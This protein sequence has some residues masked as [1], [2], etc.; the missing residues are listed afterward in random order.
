MRR[1]WAS[2]LVALFSFSLIVPVLLAGDAESALPACCRRN[3]AHRCGMLT[4]HASPDDGATAQAA[5][6]PSFPSGN[7]LTPTW[8]Q[9]GALGSSSQVYAAIAAQRTAHPQ[10]QSLY[11]IAYS[12]GSQ[13]RG[14]PSL[15]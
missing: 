5:R 11:R 2:V 1:V 3:G 14:P 6:C 4:G 9:A 10:T 15:S 7:A 13:K 8:R 12:R